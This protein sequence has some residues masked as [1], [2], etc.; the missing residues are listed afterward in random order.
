MNN[1]KDALNFQ[2]EGK[3]LEAIEAYEKYFV[4]GNPT[5]N[6]YIDLAVIYH[7]AQRGGFCL[8]LDLDTQSLDRFD[9]RFT[10]L[11]DEAEKKYGTCTEIDFWRKYT[12][13]VHLGEPFNCEELAARGDSLLPFFFLFVTTPYPEEMKKYAPKCREL[14]EL[15]KDRTTIK[16]Q[17]L[18]SFL[19]RSFEEIERYDRKRKM[20][21]E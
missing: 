10:Q 18:E 9:K 13:W 15:V 19:R 8:S 2:I 12:N 5:L 3:Y 17:I 14:Y 7:D 20:K 21:N 6:D 16:K 4:E 1:K 11:L